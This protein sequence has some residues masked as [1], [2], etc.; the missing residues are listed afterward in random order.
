[1]ALHVLLIDDDP[2]SLK[3]MS[4]A[5]RLLKHTCDALSDPRKAVDQYRRHAAYDLV[6]TD[7]YMPAINGVALAAKIRA[8]NPEAVIIFTSGQAMEMAGGCI[9]E[10]D[11]VVLRKPIDFSTLKQTLEQLEKKV[12]TT[13]EER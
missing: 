11:K 6:I 12:K 4:I 2:G 1:M 10:A 3:G 8:V 9:N 5:L 13:K 7:V